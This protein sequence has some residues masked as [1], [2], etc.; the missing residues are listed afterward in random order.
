MRGIRDE[1]K[2][3]WKLDSQAIVYFASEDERE[4][5]KT[6]LGALEKDGLRMFYSVDLL[7]ILLWP[8]KKK[9]PRRDG[10]DKEK[11]K[12]NEK[13]GWVEMGEEERKEQRESEMLGALKSQRNLI[14]GFLNYF[15][16]V[17]WGSW[18]RLART[19]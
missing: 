17:G 8:D 16:S 11:K 13:K 14:F 18:K 7:S 12:E 10:N 19:R 15:F 4:P 5:T 9:T 2:N 3:S 1:K 6:G